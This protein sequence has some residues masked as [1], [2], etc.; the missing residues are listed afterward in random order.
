MHRTVVS[1][2]ERNLIRCHPLIESPAKIS[3]PPYKSF[4]FFLSLLRSWNSSHLSLVSLFL[5]FSLP[6]F[7]FSSLFWVWISPLGSG[8]L[9][10]FF[11][12][13]WDWW[14]GWW[15]RWDFYG[16]L[17]FFCLQG[18]SCNW[19]SWRSKTTT[20]LGLWGQSKRK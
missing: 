15:D 2:L 1:G 8:F 9:R 10:W 7:F 19:T 3:K 17:W 6:L 12:D 18:F 16:F 14:C 4:S 20:R 5:C 13:F 11:V